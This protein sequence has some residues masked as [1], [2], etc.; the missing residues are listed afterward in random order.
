MGNKIMAILEACYREFCDIVGD[1]PCGCEACPYMD[2]STEDN[3]EG[4]KEAYFKDKIS[5]EDFY[6]AFENWKGEQ[7]AE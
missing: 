5:K 6:K 2:Y 4:C 7:N 3:E 1:S